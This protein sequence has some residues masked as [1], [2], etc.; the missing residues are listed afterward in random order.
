MGSRVFRESRGDSGEVRRMEGVRVEGV[1]RTVE[2][3]ASIEWDGA[4]VA[5]TR[6]EGGRD[7]RKALG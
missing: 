5:A 1:G 4:C 3:G 7:A 6:L 2:K